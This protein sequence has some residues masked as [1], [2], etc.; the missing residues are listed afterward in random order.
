MNLFEQKKQRLKK[1]KERKINLLCIFSQMQKCEIQY[2]Q[3]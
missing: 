2:D 3:Q 1:W